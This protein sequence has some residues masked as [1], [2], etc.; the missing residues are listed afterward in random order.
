MIWMVSMALTSNITGDSLFSFFVGCTVLYAYK[1]ATAKKA[2]GFL[3]CKAS[4][5]FGKWEHAPWAKKLPP[6]LGVLRWINKVTSK[7]WIE[8]GLIPSYTHCNVYEP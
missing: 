5:S 8:N 7:V 4:V 1:K 2:P 3:V 6:V